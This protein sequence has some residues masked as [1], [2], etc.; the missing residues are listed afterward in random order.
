MM[1]QSLF[2]PILDQVDSNE[3]FQVNIILQTWSME[4]IFMDADSDIEK[5]APSILVASIKPFEVKGEV[6]HTLLLPQLD[7][8]FVAKV[9]TESFYATGQGKNEE[10]A[11]EDIKVAIEMLLEE[12]E[13]PSGDA[14]WPEDYQ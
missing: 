6:F 3:T 13:N 9:N 5:L 11:L 14:P 4:E 1:K 7:G 2:Q 10:K 8:S 12:E